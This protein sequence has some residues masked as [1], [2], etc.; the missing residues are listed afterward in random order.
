MA[1]DRPLFITVTGP[2]KSGKTSTIEALIPVLKKAGFRVATL[3]HTMHDHCFDSPGTDSYRHAQAGAGR[4]GI[5][6]PSQI[7]LFGYD[8]PMKEESEDPL[9][10]EFYKD[11]DVVLCEGF[12]D[13]PFAKIVLEGDEEEIVDYQPPIIVRFKPI[14][15]LGTN[16]IIPEETLGIVLTYIQSHQTW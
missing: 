2:K 12:R 11:C 9:M 10:K 8:V 4:V 7:V 5:S 16:S 13:S 14:H 1:S 3:K 6:S 15:R